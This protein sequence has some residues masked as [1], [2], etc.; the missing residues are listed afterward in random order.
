MVISKL[1]VWILSA[2]KIVYISAKTIFWQKSVCSVLCR[3]FSE[4]CFCPLSNIRI[5]YFF[6]KVYWRGIK[7]ALLSYKFSWEKAFWKLFGPKLQISKLNILKSTSGSKILKIWIC[8]DSS[9]RSP[10]EPGRLGKSASIFPRISP[11]ESGKTRNSEI[12]LDAHTL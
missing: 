2:K 9:Q 10:I 11:I 7:K 3:T 6:L 1:F 12:L 4:S 5:S 8:V